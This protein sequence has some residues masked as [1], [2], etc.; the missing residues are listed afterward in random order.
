MSQCARA[1]RGAEFSPRIWRQFAVK[2]G[3]ELWWRRRNRLFLFVSHWMGFKL[4][5]ATPVLLTAEL[6][7]VATRLPGP[8]FGPV[9]S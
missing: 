8:P 7:V 1:P 5:A 2:P 6:A 9:E 3:V 4:G